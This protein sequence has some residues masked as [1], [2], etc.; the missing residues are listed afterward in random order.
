VEHSV[1]RTYVAADDF[2]LP[3]LEEFAAGTEWWL[4]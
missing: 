2:R 4:R 3:P 1:A